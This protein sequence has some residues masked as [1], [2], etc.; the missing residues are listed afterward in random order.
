MRKNRKLIITI[1]FL[2]GA[3]ALVWAVAELSGQ[4]NSLAQN[5]GS[6]SAEMEMVTLNLI[7]KPAR[8]INSPKPPPCNWKQERQ[9]KKALDANDARYSQLKKKA[10]QEMK[11]TGRVSSSTAAQLRSTAKAFD[12]LCRQYASM[13]EA[14][15]CRT[16]AKT[17]RKSGLARVRSAEVVINAFDNNKLDEMR[18]AQKEMKDARREYAYKAIDGSEI[19]AVDQKDIRENIIPQIDGMISRFTELVNK[20]TSIIMDIKG[21]FSGGGSPHGGGRDDSQATPEV[22]QAVQRM[23]SV[24]STGNDMLVQARE[25]KS[26]AV[27]LAGGARPKAYTAYIPIDIGFL[28]CFIEAS[29]Y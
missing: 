1:I 15:N 20:I 2:L 7:K 16:R 9:I 19:S 25:L 17:A 21:G 23:E 22:R 12:N 10:K 5:T 11:S 26:D 24:R 18:K 4:A 14:C 8:T 27:G 3:A 13:W 6:N 28:P 29:G